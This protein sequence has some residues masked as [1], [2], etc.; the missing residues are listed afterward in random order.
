MAVIW[1]R[2]LVLCRQ[3]ADR[4]YRL[5]QVK[6][7][8]GPCGP[9]SSIQYI[10]SHFRASPAFPRFFFFCWA[11]APLPLPSAFG[12]GLLQAPA[13]PPTPTAAFFRVFSNF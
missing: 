7:L 6:A 5:Q 2:G 1:L 3:I 10:T 11:R 8:R 4:I 13:T 12:F 9:T